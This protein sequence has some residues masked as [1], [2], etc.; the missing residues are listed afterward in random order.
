MGLTRTGFGA[1]AISG[2]GWAYAWRGEDDTG[3]IAA[4]RAA[5]AGT[6]PAPPPLTAPARQ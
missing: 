5:G 6:G 1:R 3:S 2:G 4:V